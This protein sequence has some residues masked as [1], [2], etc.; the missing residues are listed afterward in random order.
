MVH[1]LGL[2]MREEWEQLR[3]SY[4]IDDQDVSHINR[5]RI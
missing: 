3:E 5:C 1:Y 2:F 4:E